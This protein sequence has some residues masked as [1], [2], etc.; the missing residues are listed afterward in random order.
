MAFGGLF[1]SSAPS[2]PV[3]QQPKFDSETVATILEIQTKV[4]EEFAINT[5]KTL[6]DH[7]TEQCFT[8]CLKAP[9]AVSS[10]SLAQDNN[11]VESCLAKYLRSWNEISKAYVGRLQQQPPN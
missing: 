1:G 3:P 10:S 6:V 11:C 7:A 2:S 5:A 4:Q 9:Y 8:K